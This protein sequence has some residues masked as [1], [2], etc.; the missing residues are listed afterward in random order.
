MTQVNIEATKNCW[1]SLTGYRTLFVLRLLLEKSRTI[2]EL[3]NLLSKNDLANKSVSKD[4]IRLTINTLKNAGCNIKRPCKTNGY[5]YEILSHPFTLQIS[6]KELSAFIKLRE[7]ASK[8]MG[9]DDIFKLNDLYKKFF[10]LT[11]NQDIINEINDTE[12]LYDIDKKILKEFLNP[13]IMGKEVQIKYNSAGNGNE[14]LVIVPQKITYENGKIYLNCFNFKYQNTSVLSLDKI[15]EIKTIGLKNIDIKEKYYSV[16]YKVFGSSILN[17][18]IK[19][20]EEIIAKNDDFIVVRAI[21]KS[22]FFFVQRLLLLGSDF[23][24]ISPAFFKEKLVNKVKAIQGRYNN[25]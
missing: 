11:E 15:L 20:N 25:G 19:D 17:F 2:D 23:T 3:I 12:L 9:L 16:E 18:E 4:T 8:E 13:K 5:K 21:V 22:E 7:E 14:D 1:I 10:S 6:N 24:I